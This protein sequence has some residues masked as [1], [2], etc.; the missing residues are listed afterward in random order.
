MLQKHLQ[1]HHQ[2]HD[3]LLSRLLGE[4]STQIDPKG[5]SL[6]VA[7]LDT[8]IHPML[9]IGDA[10]ALYL[11]TFVDCKSIEKQI[12][13]I[14][15]KTKSRL[16]V[17]IT[18]PILFI[19]RELHEYFNGTL[20]LFNTPL[21]FSGTLFQQ[22]VWNALK[23]IPYGKTCSYATLAHAVGNPAAHRAV[24]QANHVNPFTI[25]IP[26]HRVIYA[27]G[28]LGGY[29]GGIARKQWL[30]EHEQKLLKT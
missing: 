9:A 2:E 18:E 25:V 12:A 17:G 5:P 15:N 30:I 14:K 23:N 3:T 29:G 20:R 24:A 16:T 13:R 7:L 8:P 6:K 26:C 27:N 28:T 1:E 19:Q 22:S 11:L 10:H 4:E 21:F